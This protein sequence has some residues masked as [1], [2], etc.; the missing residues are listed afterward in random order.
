MALDLTPGTPLMARIVSVT[1][2]GVLQTAEVEVVD[3]AGNVVTGVLNV[4][5]GP[6]IVPA[7]DTFATIDAR[8]GQQPTVSLEL[9]NLGAEPGVPVVTATTTQTATDGTVTTVDLAWT[10]TSSPTI[11]AATSAGPG[12]AT[13]TMQTSAPLAAADVGTDNVSFTVATQAAPAA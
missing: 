1:R 10:Q 7:S 9:Q 8:T 5:S 12:T 11:P 4:A 13:V 6:W 3:M 2:S